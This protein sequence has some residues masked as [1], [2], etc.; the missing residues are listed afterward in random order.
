MEVSEENLSILRGLFLRTLA[1]DNAGRKEAEAYLQSIEAQPGFPLVLLHLISLLSSS[2]TSPEDALIRQSASVMFKNL[3]KRRW[4]PNATEDDEEKLAPIAEV[5]RG[6]IKMHLVELMCST[7]DAVQRLLAEAVTIVSNHDFPHLWEGLL[8]QLVSKLATADA[9]VT[10][11]VMSTVNSIMKRFRYVYKTESL[12]AQLKFCLDG[13]QIPLLHTFQGNFTAIQGMA[14]NKAAL[15]VLLETQRLMARIFFSLNWQDLPEYFEDNMQLWM[16]EFVK[17]LTYTNPL[18][19]DATE[20]TEP[21]PIEKLQAAVI[22]DITLYA[23]KY[24]EEFT[25][26]LPTFAQLTW[27]LLTAVGPQA[28]YDILATSSIKFLTSVC[29]KHMNQSIFTDQVL[30]DI[31]NQIVVP[32]LTASSSDEELFEDNPTDYMRKDIE[33]GDQ[34]TRRRSAS[35][36]VRAMLKFHAEKTSELC[37][38]YIS[39]MLEQYRTTMDWR[40]KDAALHLVL[41]VAVMSTSSNIGAGELNPRINVLDVFNVHVVP[42]VQEANVDARPI[43]KADAIKLI[44][45]FRSHLQT[46]F[47]LSLLP[48]IIRHLTSSQVVIQ[49]YAAMC[50]ERFLAVKDRDAATGTMAT[51]ITKDQ[52]LPYLQPLFTGLFAVLQNPELS[53]NDYV[54]KCIMR[55]LS[56]IGADVAPMTGAVLQQLTAA[57]Q[58]VC[59]NPAN[60]HF[61]H[62]LFECLA[63]LVRSCCSGVAPDV[64]AAACGNFEALLFP[65]FQ[66][67]LQ[68][69][70]TEFTPYVFQILAQLL[71]SRPSPGLSDF[72]RVL[73]EPLLSPL[74]WERRG[75][76]P[77]LTDLFRAYISKGMAEIIEGNYLAGML[78]VFQKLL[79]NKA[80]EAFAF[81]VLDSLFTSNPIE[82]LA[83]YLP[84]IFNLLLVRMQDQMK[85]DNKTPRYC[86]MFIH[87]MCLFA[88]V[89]GAQL[90][91][92]TLEG[93]SGGLTA[94]IITKVWTVNSSACSGCDRSEVKRMVVGATKLLTDTPIRQQ[95]DVWKCLLKFIVVLLSSSSSGGA[96]TDG[97]GIDEEAEAREFDSTYSRLAYAHVPEPALSPEMVTAPA[98]FATS[99]ATLSSSMP[100]QYTPLV[101]AALS[102]EEASQLT[103]ILQH[104]GVGLV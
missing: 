22:D 40:A 33:G 17:C 53:E 60:P 63:L 27:Q 89:Y 64:S 9:Q 76:V 91:Y 32:N 42:E 73:L 62:Y 61:N 19:V 83:Q 79:A 30:Q 104:S 80:T 10:K 7:P 75:N 25:P 99:L 57:L 29:S 69:D 85:A 93:L 92:D 44:C 88:S 46:P 103:A 78:G 72:Y 95:P 97:D 51:R 81:K 82:V 18:L 28:K 34:D 35:E 59:K 41:A 21:G 5:D 43:V 8:P 11:G 70:V 56:V 31:V 67:V 55:V 4:H 47:L 15:E 45:I 77:A 23:T 66:D 13:F 74:L 58:R 98:F 14:G 16:G 48:D 84:T 100:G 38:A 3:I 36:L 37:T 96:E 26:F 102:P 94:M 12:F 87:T 65:P 1:A 68:N 49:T 20:D 52:L 54:M 86:R 90:L 24:E 71:S 50:I 6:A 2:A 101:Q 39:G